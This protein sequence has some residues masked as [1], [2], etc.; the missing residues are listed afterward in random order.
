[1]VPQLV[2]RRENQCEGR[3][4]GVGPTAVEGSLLGLTRSYKKLF[5]RA[6]HVCKMF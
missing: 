4:E 6:A 1:M 2:A 5:A 3:R